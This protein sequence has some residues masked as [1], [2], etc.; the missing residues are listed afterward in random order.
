[1]AA[2]PAHPE[3]QTPPPDDG[4]GHKLRASPL[5]RRAAEEAGVDLAHVRGT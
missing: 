2:P 3:P 1:M 4:D 5:A